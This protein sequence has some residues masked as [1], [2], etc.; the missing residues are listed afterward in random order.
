MKSIV[1]AIKSTVDLAVD[2]KAAP[3]AAAPPAFITSTSLFG[4]TWQNWMYI[5]ASVYSVLLI[6]GWVWNAMRKLRK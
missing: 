4:V 1:E 3:V 2:S 6:A 5:S